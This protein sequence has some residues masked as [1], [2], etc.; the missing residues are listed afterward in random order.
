MLK[1]QTR[2]VLLLATAALA[3]TALAA[4]WPAAQPIKLKDREMRTADFRV[5]CTPKGT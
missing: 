2:L 5:R 1:F 3:G 4:D